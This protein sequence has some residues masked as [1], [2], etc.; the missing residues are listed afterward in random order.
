MQESTFF[1][2]TVRMVKDWSRLSR[3]LV[4]SPSA[5]MLKT[6]LDM[7]FGNLFQLTLL[8]L[9]GWIR[10][11]QEREVPSNLNNSA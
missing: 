4:K 7:V 5:E 11:S 8:E 3:Q 10:S 1:F 2:F 6:Y 9:G